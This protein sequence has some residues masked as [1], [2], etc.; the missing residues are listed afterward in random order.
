[1]PID[2]TAYNLL[3]DDSGS[4]LDGS[5]WDKADV[6]A[7]L[8][9]IDANPIWTSYVPV[10]GNTGTGNTLG[11]STIAGKYYQVGKSVTFKLI[12]SLGNTGAAGSGAYTFTL[13]TTVGGSW[14]DNFAAMLTDAS[15]GS[16]VAIAQTYLTDKCVVMAAGAPNGVTG[17]LPFAWA[18]GDNI[19]ITGTY[20][21][22]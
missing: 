19:L 18:V 4:G 6:D 21:A 2:R 12:F 5:V 10:W 7:I 14:G 17:A 13:P 22:A 16:Y 9:A 20:E 15:V 1:M 8:D 3:V 11:N